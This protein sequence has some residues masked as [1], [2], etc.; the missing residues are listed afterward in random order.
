MSLSQNIN[1]YID[2][3]ISKYIRIIATKYSL[4][5]DSLL[6]EWRGGVLTPQT[7][8]SESK[9]SPNTPRSKVVVEAKQSPDTP[10]TNE[11]MQLTKQEL[12]EKC[13]PDDIL[14]VGQLKKFACS[15]DKFNSC[16]FNIHHIDIRTKET[17]KC[18]LNWFDNLKGQDISIDNIQKIFSDSIK[19]I[20]YYGI[21]KSVDLTNSFLNCFINFLDYFPLVDKLIRQ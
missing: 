2:D 11:L 1:S 18:F 6:S 17:L 15:I 12:Q 7:K 14:C 3:T 16:K 21:D 10:D 5:Y 13:K 8:V 9:Q 4:D 19:Y 20:V